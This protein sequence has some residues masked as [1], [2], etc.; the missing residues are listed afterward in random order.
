RLLALLEKAELGDGGADPPDLL[1][2]EA[3][4]L[5]APVT[6]DEG[7]GVAFV[8]ELDGARDGAFIEAQLTCQAG[9]ISRGRECHERTPGFES[10]EGRPAE[11]GRRPRG[12]APIAPAAARH[13]SALPVDRRSAMAEGDQAA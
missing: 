10:V 12:C 13:A 6:G 5:I 1:F 2:I 8:E 11:R 4:R 7:D 3:A 9:V